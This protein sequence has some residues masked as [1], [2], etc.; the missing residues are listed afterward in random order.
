MDIELPDNATDEFVEKIKDI[1][2]EC[3][4]RYIVGHIEK[5]VRSEDKPDHAI[6]KAIVYN[7]DSYAKLALK[8]NLCFYIEWIEY[9]D[10]SMLPA[11]SLFRMKRKE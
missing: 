3:Q 6:A 1:P 11:T 5:A 2:I 8:N 10:G 7:G 9:D 4:G